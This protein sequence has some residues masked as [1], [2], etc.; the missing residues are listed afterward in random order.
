M[1]T[2]TTNTLS[3][4]TRQHQTRVNDQLSNAIERLSSGLRINSARDDAAGQAMAN[5]MQTN[6]NADRQISRGMSDGI[7]LAQ[8]AEGGLDRIN[9]LLQRGREL[10]VQSANGTLSDPDR[11][12]LNQ[13]FLSL[14][15]EID[16]ISGS[17]E[18]FGKTPLAGEAA[19]T[20]IKLGDTPHVVDVFDD[21]SQ[22]YS[23][24]VK[25]IAYVPAGTTNFTLNINSY[26]QDDDI[27]LFTTDGKH[28]IG[29]PVNGTS[30]YTWTH[31]GITDGATATTQLLNTSDGFD[32]GA[33]YDDSQFVDATGSYSRP[34][35]AATNNYN[36]MTIGYS[37]D[38][39]RTAPAT[40]PEFN[41]GRLNGSETSETVE[42]LTVDNVT[43]NLILFMS[44]EGSFTASASWD[45]LPGTY[46]KDPNAA[47][48]SDTDIVMS[49]DYGSAMSTLTIKA[50]P[51]DSKS[52]GIDNTALDPIEKAREA[53]AE[54][55]N[56]ILKVDDYRSQYG[57]A[58][59]R[60]EGAIDTVSDKRTITSAAQSRIMDADYAQESSRMT[61]ARII[62]DAANAMLAQANQVPDAML[63][64]LK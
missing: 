45:T 64:L 1:A 17:T 30:D 7:S 41:N 23:S 57:A 53:M 2:I 39:D 32:P 9:D 6:L 18:I 25:A 24:G 34:G 49:A 61:R 54:L 63:S 27:Q 33:T 20:G 5:R 52:L 38:G 11:A 16:R 35:A 10:A 58:Q 31:N 28:L 60:L 12:T 15:A 37:G 29:T 46:M 55:D 62:S 42:T 26:N 59:N 44:G 50:T 4:T 3:L 22:S 13:E 21:G 43:E 8:T 51:S 40:D 19:L 48:S 36:G 47:A 14:R 56:A